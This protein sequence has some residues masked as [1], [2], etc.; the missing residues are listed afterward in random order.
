MYLMWL[1]KFI[2]ESSH[3]WGSLL[4]TIM[5][6][7]LPQ[8]RIEPATTKILHHVTLIIELWALAWGKG[9]VYMSRAS[10][11]VKSISKCRQM[12]ITRKKVHS[13]SPPCLTFNYVA[14]AQVQQHK[15]PCVTITS[16]L[17][18][19]PPMFESSIVAYFNPFLPFSFS[20]FLTLSY[21]PS[22]LLLQ[23]LNAYVLFTTP[24]LLITIVP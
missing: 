2:Y 21:T 11:H 24:M 14:L 6:L 16:D 18:W 7:K 23:Q 15:Y 13:L 17:S 8:H 20:P 5:N 10:S 22:R 4:E 19:I 3:L 1:Y 9:G 12:F